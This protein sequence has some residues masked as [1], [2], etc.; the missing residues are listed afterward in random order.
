MKEG[1][2]RVDPEAPEVDGCR[3]R[4]LFLNS[5][6]DVSAHVRHKSIL[7]KHKYYQFD[8]CLVQFKI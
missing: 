8:K 1:L 3:E 2:Y 6:F 5:L 4:D 7:L